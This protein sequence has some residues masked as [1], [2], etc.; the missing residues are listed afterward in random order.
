MQ[1]STHTHTHTANIL[2]HM[3][4]TDPPPQKLALGI[5]SNCSVLPKMLLQISLNPEASTVTET[6]VPARPMTSTL[7][8]KLTSNLEKKWVYHTRNVI[9][10]GTKH[11]A[12]IYSPSSRKLWVEKGQKTLARL[13]QQ[14]FSKKKVTTVGKS[15]NEHW[16][17]MC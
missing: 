8:A 1:A 3:D 10:L 9:V 13:S 4:F 17:T 12:V 16:P 2:P 11:R 7:R 5:I 14:V 15:W 6:Q